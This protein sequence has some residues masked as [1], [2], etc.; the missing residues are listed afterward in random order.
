[1][2]V[3]SHAARTLALLTVA[4][5]A[6]AA[7]PPATI[8]VGGLTLDYCNSDYDGYCGSIVQPLDPL[9]HLPGSISIGF[10]FYPRFDQA[11]AGLGT[12]LPQEGGPGYSSTGTRDAYVPLFTPLRNHRDILIVDKRGTGTSG[13]LDC[14]ALQAGTG[15]YAAA[16][17]AC[18]RQLGK[19]AWYYGSALAAADV[20][21][22][23]DALAIDRVDY[24][25]DSYGTYFG[26]TMAAR[27]PTRLRSIVLDSAYPVR[28]P[29]AW[30]PTDWT[31]AR[32]GYDL[33]CTRSVSCQQL[34]HQS[35]ALLTRL[36]N[37]VRRHPIG[38]WAPAAFLPNSWSQRLVCSSE[39]RPCY[40]CWEA[41]FPDQA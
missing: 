22:V 31:T 1:M 40:S 20:V 33:V 25:G 13:P 16:L 41:S 3:R 6:A 8:V 21:A 18:G 23:L 15:N 19:S 28:P 4:Y 11:H 12:I 27:F 39:L 30:F 37:A 34:G 17:A 5:G 29:D 10:E 32:D 9:T 7:S 38:G 26:Q 2:S 36:L 14:P 35:T 24:Y